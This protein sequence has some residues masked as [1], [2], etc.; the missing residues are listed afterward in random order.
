MRATDAIVNTASVHDPLNHDVAVGEVRH[1]QEDYHPSPK[2]P[3]LSGPCRV[4]GLTGS[5]KCTGLPVPPA[6]WAN[7][8]GLVHIERAVSAQPHGRSLA[9]T[10]AFHQGPTGV[11]HR[12]TTGENGSANR[13]SHLL[14]GQGNSAEIA[15]DFRQS[16]PRARDGVREQAPAAQLLADGSFWLGLN[17]VQLSDA[18]AVRQ[19]R[20]QRAQRRHGL[21]S[22]AFMRKH[23]IRRIAA[24]EPIE[25][26]AWVRRKVN[27]YG[28]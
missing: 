5:D 19:G 2:A 25:A 26:P 28:I 11:S 23:G 27:P 8:G 6:V 21:R 4:N 3:R 18:V 17:R 9:E 13:A 12:Q 24:P 7:E 22:A 20:H 14:A 15:R 1:H 10:S 16:E